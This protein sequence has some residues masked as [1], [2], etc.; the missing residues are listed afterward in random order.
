[1]EIVLAETRSKDPDLVIVGERVESTI[2]QQDAIIG[3][4]GTIRR[5]QGDLLGE[6][7]DVTVALTT[8][9]DIK[10]W[11]AT[12]LVYIAIAVALVVGAWM[13]WYTGIGAFVRG[14]LG[15]VTPSKK[16]EAEI[17]YAALSDKD[18]TTYREMI[19]ARRAADPDFDRAFRKVKKMKRQNAG[20]E[21]STISPAKQQENT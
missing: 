15:I 13:L 12:M 18:P 19:A 2:A 3:H 9:Q 7:D 8:V 6:V 21:S 4:A 1:M 20:A 11:W 16:R 10:P 17:T 5:L 14:L